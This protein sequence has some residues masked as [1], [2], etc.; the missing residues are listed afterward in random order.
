MTGISAGP[1]RRRLLALLLIGACRLASADGTASDVPPS[2]IP[3]RDVHE[4][5][6]WE[7][8]LGGGAVVLNDYPGASSSHAYPVPFGY[9]IYNGKFL[10]SDRDGVRGLL[11]NQSW[12]ELNVSANLTA[13]VRNNAARNGMPE[14]RSTVEIGPSLNFHLFRSDAGR[15]KL[16]LNLPLRSAFTIEF[17]PRSIGWV[18]EPN[19]DLDFDQLPHLPDWHLGFAAGPMYANARYHEYF[20]SVGSQYA[21]ATRPE[22][23]APGGYSGAQFVTV[24]TKRFLRFRIAAYLHYDTLAGASFVDSPLVERRH[25]WSGGFGIAWTIG[26]STQSVEV[27]N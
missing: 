15:V 4:A 8:G 12:V 14:L 11:L 1:S 19:L 20:Y 13:P 23:E 9:L 10:K 16:D 3:A 2:D 24:V 17:P 18:F 6:L 27:P 7:Y 5:P 21:T 25:D 22:Y 26:R